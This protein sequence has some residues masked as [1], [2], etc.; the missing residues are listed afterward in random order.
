MRLGPT[1]RGTH[2]PSP[3]P[4][5]PPPPLPHTHKVSREDFK[6]TTEVIEKTEMFIQADGGGLKKVSVPEEKHKQPALSEGQAAAIGRLLKALEERLGK[7]QDFEWAYENGLYCII[8][9][10]HWFLPNC[11]TLHQQELVASF[12]GFPSSFPSLGSWKGSLGTRLR[13]W[14][15]YHNY[16]N[17]PFLHTDTYMYAVVM[18]SYRTFL[19]LVAVK[20]HNPDP[21]QASYTA[22]RHVQ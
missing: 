4:P 17:A 15:M 8:S 22:S 5:P 1:D 13:N 9:H 10:L 19:Y 3:S 7:P 11:K 12:P 20:S 21:P 16:N 18:N 2:N 6:V 14:Y